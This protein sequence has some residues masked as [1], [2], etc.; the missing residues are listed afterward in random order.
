MTVATLFKNSKRN[1]LLK[2]LFKDI[3]GEEVG[4]G[5][6]KGKSGSSN[7]I[8]AGHRVNF[9]KIKRFLYLFLII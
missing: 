3:G 4:G 9:F 1:A 2:H 6:K 5:G 7:T 8:S